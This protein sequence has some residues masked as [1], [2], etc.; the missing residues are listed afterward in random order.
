VE[1]KS[2]GNRLNNAAFQRIIKKFETVR[3]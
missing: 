1:K 2:L 3:L